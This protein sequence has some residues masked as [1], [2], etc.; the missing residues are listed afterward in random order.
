VISSNWASW[1]FGKEE[2][3]QLHLDLTVKGSD[4]Q[5]TLKVLKPRRKGADFVIERKNVVKFFAS[6][7]WWRARFVAF[8]KR[9]SDE[10]RRSSR[11]PRESGRPR[12]RCRGRFMN[13]AGEHPMNL[14]NADPQLAGDVT[15]ALSL[16]SKTTG[17][18]EV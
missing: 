14:A 4:G 16:R 17:S 13:A 7:R 8:N 10:G 18:V 2:I 6:Y 3:W 12:G 1:A 5:M 9:S 15:K 11:E